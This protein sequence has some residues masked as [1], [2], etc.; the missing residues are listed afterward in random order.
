VAADG[1]LV[2]NGG[3][4]RRDKGIPPSR[5]LPWRAVV[6]SIM[7]VTFM[8]A[9]KPARRLASG[10]AN[11]ECAM[12]E[13]DLTKRL[14]ACYTGVVHDVM[15]AMGLK[16]FTLPPALRPLLPEATLAGPVF[17]IEGRIDASA[18]AHQTL[19]EWTGLLSKAKPGH[20]WVSQPNDR[21][22]AHMGE[23]SA[24][25]LKSKGVR[26]CVVDGYVRDVHFLL[27]MGFQT[28]AR[29]F[30]PRDI[31]GY[32]LPSGFDVPIMIGEV[33][34]EP[35]DF[36]LADRDG[37]VRLPR[38]MVEEIIDKAEKAMTTESQVRRAILEGVDPQQ[39]YLRFGKF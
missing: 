1:G 17:T 36:L 38:G 16:E 31:V 35:G 7:R 24:E 13:A 18:D 15:R 3:A 26:G 33:R 5:R 27:E 10:L 8:R 2:I 14:G 32:W 23:L 6:G 29:G 11:G 39:A 28:W 34:I 19:L 22:V 37:A 25:A 21:V 12:D 4:S 20:V 30:T 9:T